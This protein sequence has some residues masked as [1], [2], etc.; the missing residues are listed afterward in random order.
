M[1]KLWLV[2]PPEALAAREI[3]DDWR[4]AKALT[5]LADKLS[6]IQKNQLFSHWRDTLHILSVRT[7]PNLLID[8][9]ALTP[10]MFTLGGQQAVKD[11]VYA[12]QY[13]SRWWH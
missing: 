1:G 2:L 8:I 6:L 11:T 5:S 12:I 10:V 9:E 13:V 7:R 4:R 3:Q